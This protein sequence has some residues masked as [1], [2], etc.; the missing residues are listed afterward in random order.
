M[1]EK[2][3][4]KEKFNFIKLEEIVLLISKAIKAGDFGGAVDLSNYGLKN[5]E[6]L[7]YISQL[8][9]Y[10]NACM[11]FFSNGEV[12]K[13]IEIL[14]EI[15]I[16]DIMLLDNENRYKALQIIGYA[17]FSMEMY[18]DAMKFYRHANRL[19]VEG[20]DAGKIA[21]S[22]LNMIECMI[23]I[24]WNDDEVR[25]KLIEINE[26]INNSVNSEMIKAWFQYKVVESKV[27]GKNSTDFTDI[28]NLLKH[29]HILVSAGQAEYKKNIL[30]YSNSQLEE[31]LKEISN[32]AKKYGMSATKLEIDNK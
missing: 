4:K 13:S 29:I 27:F 1:S 17:Y 28:L 18:K 19:A 14:N 7:D 20:G 26:I 6:N 9:L 15:H 8:K 2:T 32:D 30:N 10:V 22:G 31:T 23:K 11:A 24:K 5:K 12:E 21:E 3:E 25:N 16:S